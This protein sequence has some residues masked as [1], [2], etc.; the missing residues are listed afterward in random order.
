MLFVGIDVAKSHHDVAILDHDGT[1]IL[2]HLRIQN[3]RLGFELLITKLNELTNQLNQPV[4]I[5]MESTG[6]Y[7]TNIMMFMQ[8]HGYATFLY[9][10][11]LIKEFVKS[12]SLRKT[13]TDKA[14]SLTIAK[15]FA[16]DVTPE[17]FAISHEIQELR[18]YLVIVVD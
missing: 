14:D 6:H 10:S 3:T 11:F 8:S 16:S 12:S 13:K 15:K 18:L 7:C 17:Q 1:I 4:R 9:N 2:R 5:A